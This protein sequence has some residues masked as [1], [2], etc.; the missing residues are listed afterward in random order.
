MISTSSDLAENRSRRVILHYWGRRG[1]GSQVTL[2]LAQHLTSSK[3]KAEV[4]FS[5][6]QQNS[7]VEMFRASGL[8][9]LT[10]DR[11]GLCNLWRK[12]WTLP[13]QLRRHADALAALKPNAVI[14]TMNSPFAWPFIHLLKRRQLRVI[15]VAHDAEPHPGDYAQLWQR[16]TQDRLIRAADQIVTLSRNVATRIARRLPAAAS[17]TVVVPLEAIYPTERMPTETRPVPSGPV[18]LLFTAGC[19]PTRD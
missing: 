17:K 3:H 2:N 10:F 1:G 11:P 7:D 15:Y 18:Q 13:Q 16:V 6:A 5:L 12:T 8:P 4:F 19:C 9:I 14:M